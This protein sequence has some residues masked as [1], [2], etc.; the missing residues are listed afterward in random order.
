MIYE[1]NIRTVADAVV[2]DGCLFH[3]IG[4]QSA[5]D[6]RNLKPTGTAAVKDATFSDA[7]AWANAG[8]LTTGADTTAFCDL[9]LA[10]SVFT[11]D[12]YTVVFGFRFKKAVPAGTEVFIGSF[13]TGTHPGGFTLDGR[14][15]GT[16][17]MTLVALDGATNGLSITAAAGPNPLDEAEHTA[18]FVWPRNSASAQAWMDGRQITTGA[19]ANVYGKDHR[20]TRA[21]RIGSA[22]GTNAAKAAQIAMVCAYQIP[23]DIG[24]IN[25]ALIAD[26]LH[27]NPGM[28]LEN[29]HL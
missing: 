23:K 16:C 29:W 26:Y 13:T 20:G 24:D 7:E 11:L 19:A 22:P 15:D 27:R 4:E 9:A 10:E 17:R 18:V 1:Q 28:P 14:A 6:M 8:Y 12:G 25:I 2:A 3:L 5:G 21:L